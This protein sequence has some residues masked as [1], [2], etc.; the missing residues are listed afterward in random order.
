[1]MD[2]LRPLFTTEFKRTEYVLGNGTWEVALTLDRGAVFT[3]D[4]K[5]PICEVELELLRGRS[6]PP[7][8][9][10]PHP[11][12]NGPH[13]A[14]HPIQVRSR[15]R[16][17]RRAWPVPMK[18]PEVPVTADMPLAEA[19]QTVG[20]ACQRHLLRNEA[21]LRELHD[22]E[23]VHQMRIAL[24]RLRSALSVFNSVVSGPETEALTAELK[25]LTDE[26]GPARDTDVFIAEI[27]DPILAVH[28]DENGLAALATRFE[29]RKATHYRRALAAIDDRRYTALMLQIG[30][31][32]EGGAWLRPDDPA[33][34]AQIAR[35]CGGFAA[36][37]LDIRHKKVLKRGKRFSVQDVCQRHRLRVQIKKLRYASEFF[38]DVWGKGK[39]VKAYVRA[40][41]ALPR[42]SGKPQRHRRRPF[43]APRDGRRGQYR[44]P[45]DLGGGLHG[46]MARSAGKRPHGV[47]T[48]VVEGLHENGPLLAQTKEGGGQGRESGTPGGPPQGSVKDGASGTV[49]GRLIIS[50]PPLQTLAGE[51]TLGANALGIGLLALGL[52][53]T[54]FQAIVGRP[55]FLLGPRLPFAGLAEVDNVGHGLH[56][57]VTMPVRTCTAVSLGDAHVA[58][59]RRQC[60]PLCH[61]CNSVT[62]PPPDIGPCPHFS[63]SRRTPEG[64]HAPAFDRPCPLRRLGGALPA[65][66]DRRAHRLGPA[67][68][69]AG[70][71]H[72]VRPD[73]AAA[74]A[75]GRDHRRVHRRR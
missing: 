59:H 52:C 20:R 40:L 27:L 72:H 36:E 30:A 19:I 45:R 44:R 73:G 25:W 56:V 46:G 41:K 68:A 70:E 2:E 11:A 57:L 53:A 47:G 15:L 69:T 48:G 61:L 24:R 49:L 51:V 21:H 9:D 26:L 66:V 43:P 6:C 71:R 31:W 35:P 29:H 10:R 17:C 65:A 50:G 55:L 54:V 39:P 23:A 63:L 58:P 5:A 64:L 12:R 16:P 67:G 37:T 32:I 75:G 28:P 18:A 22:P 62:I 13:A 4:G 42:R 33:M 7:V 34:Q 60:K 1:M 74:R 3:G 14:Q 38:S 8:R